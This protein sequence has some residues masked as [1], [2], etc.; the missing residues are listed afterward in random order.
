MGE[1]PGTLKQEV[2]EEE[3][4]AAEVDEHSESCVVCR[5][6]GDEDRLLLCDSCDNSVQP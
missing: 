1:V 4:A 3:A 2:V 6:K 5:Q